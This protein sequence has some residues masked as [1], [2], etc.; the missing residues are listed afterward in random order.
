LLDA[1]SAGSASNLP[2]PLPKCLLG[3]VRHSTFNFALP[4]CIQGI[5]KKFSTKRTSH[6]AFRFVDLQVQLVVPA[7][8]QS[9]YPLAGLLAAHVHVAVIG[10]AGKAMS[11][12]FQHPI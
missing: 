2:D 1:A 12:S 8:E 4:G 10:I 11:L 9:H 6:C 3:L 5:T 7:L